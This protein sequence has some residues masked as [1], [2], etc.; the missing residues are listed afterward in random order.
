MSGNAMLFAGTTYMS[1]PENSTPPPRMVR[2]PAE[3]VYGEELAALACND[4]SSKPPGWRLSPRAVRQFSVG[5]EAPL[6]H[7]WQ[8]NKKKTA[9][10]L[11]FYG[12]DALVERCIVTL[13]G[14]RGLLI[15]G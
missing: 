1:E 15:V 8:G 11:K 10:T 7:S 2:P 3:L 6:A 14:N 5:A 9:V 12:D 13:L 4:N